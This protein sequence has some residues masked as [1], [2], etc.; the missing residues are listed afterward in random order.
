MRKP[1]H[2]GFHKG[3]VPKF[4]PIQTAEAV[5]L[6]KSTL[7]APDQWAKYIHRMA[8]SVIMSVVYDSPMIESEEDETVTFFNNMASRLARAAAPG[9]HLVELMPFLVAVPSSF[10]KWKREVEEWYAHDSAMLE[11]LFKEVRDRVAKGEDRPSFAA[12]LIHDEGRYGLSL[13][14]NAWL[15]ASM[16]AAGSETTASVL[17]WWMRPR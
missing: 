12:T 8:A 6:A 15:A 3:F 10:A 14:E 16:C 11:S 17:L 1:T 4:H 2:E 9:A 7:A 5:L 13:R